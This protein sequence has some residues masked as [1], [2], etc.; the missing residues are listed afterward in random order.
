MVGSAVP[1]PFSRFA[2]G[3]RWGLA[4]S[5]NFLELSNVGQLPGRGHH[6]IASRAHHRTNFRILGKLRSHLTSEKKIWEAKKERERPRK[7]PIPISHPRRSLGSMQ[8][9]AAMPSR[10]P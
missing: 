5:Q 6:G 7:R 1:G 4:D 9:Q 3:R 10:T 8:N 2:L